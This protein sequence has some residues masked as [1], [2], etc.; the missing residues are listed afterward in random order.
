MLWVS[1]W[2]T[3]E[4]I[5]LSREM[6]R[7]QGLVTV[8]TRVGVL[9][10]ELQKE[11]GLSIGFIGSKGANFAA[12]LPKQRDAV[13]KERKALADALASFDASHFGAH[14]VGVMDAAS[15]ALG[16]LAE[17][18]QAVTSLG[19]PGPEAIVFYNKTVGAML[20]IPG[21]LP[22]LSP[23]AD[24]ARMSN[25]YSALLQAKERAG[26]ERATLAN[27]FGADRFAPEMLV[28]F[29]R[30]TAE[31]DTWFA[32][33]NQYATETHRQFAV[34]AIRGAAVDEV[35]EARKLAIT[36]MSEPSLGM[37]AKK[38]FVASTV[39][40]DLMKSVDDRVAGDLTGAMQ[41]LERRSTYIAWFYAITTVVSVLGILMFARVVTRRIMAELG[42]E[43]DYAKQVVEKVTNGE[44]VDVH[45][46]SGDT[47]SLLASMHEMV[48]MLKR[49]AGAQDEMARQHELGMID[50]AMPA[51]SFSG[52][53]GQMANSINT[54]V[55]SHIDV[56]M[57]VVEVVKHYADGDLSMDMDR[58]P[59][60]KAQVTAAIDGV[61]GSLQAINGQISNLVDAAVA[62]NFKARGDA[63]RF[64]HQFR[65][66]VEGLNRLMEVSDT[67]L[68]EVSR[69]LGALARGDLTQTM[70]GDYLGTFAQ[71]KDD[72]NTTVARLREVVGRIKEATEAIN[73]AAQE[74]A[75]GNQDLSS[76]TEEQASSLEETAS[77]M[78]QLNAT[79]R[80]NAENA[81]QANELAKSSNEGV[82]R[83]GEVVKRVVVTMGEIQ[84][85][86]KKIA[87]IIGVIDSIA[88]QTNILALNAAVEAARAG[89]QG[90]G[91]A[92]V[93]TE[94]RNLAQR[95][96]TAAKEIKTLIA[97]SVGK[98]DSGAKLVGEAGSTMDE[99]VRSFR[100]V[101][102]LVTE[103]SGASREQSSGIEQV[104]QAV[105]QMDEVTQQNAALVEQAAAAAESLE[106]QAR[107]LV[108]AVGMFK[109]SAG[110][111][112]TN[113]PGP[114][115][116]DV[117]PRQ[118]G[119]EARTEKPALAKPTARKAPPAHL[120]DDNEE[121][122]E[123]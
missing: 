57:R 95:S 69:I 64:N 16:G 22:A 3:V 76:R 101:A 73:T 1:G 37:D 41:A 117:T 5:L 118:L 53:Y 49:F 83:G 90:R 86:S 12:E 23:D 70:E 43:P 121:W 84:D 71:L 106:E 6:G 51:G 107:G 123:F 77:S 103:I 8:A 89:E 17:K 100:S 72:T 44:L 93:A 82:V 29:L 116:R 66:M 120:A 10:H 108:Q 59:G 42:G 94:V 35:A 15:Q 56:K 97:E 33:F 50:E 85:S 27:A 54:L 38:W 78:E 102:N 46:Q 99:V 92:V 40:I 60:K 63:E 9:V 115:L 19:I 88:F 65:D 110:G 109:L 26:V 32:I 75:A 18:R 13:D 20:D 113:L 36:K 47:H 4:K 25:S 74:I 45:L 7:L 62:G 98:V 55:K 80:Q 48:S 104:T 30:N 119:H 79:V 67:G 52:V 87:D 24:I 61:K 31:Q 21:Q 114:A 81:R 68:S 112:G 11:R 14:F 91:F 111:G 39:R 2:N 122:E 58:L 96:A 105:G 28:R 34:D